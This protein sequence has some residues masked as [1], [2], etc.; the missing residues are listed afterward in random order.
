[1]FLSHTSELRDHPVARSFVAAAEAAVIRAGHAVTDMAYFAARDA[2]PADYCSDMTAEADVYVGII[3]LCYG[4]PVLD[5]PGVSYTELEFETATEFGRPR[6]IFL[7]DESAESVPPTSEPAEHRFRQEAFRRRLL[8]DAGVTVARIASP[9]A[10]ELGLLH[11]LGELRGAWEARA[12]PPDPRAGIPPDATAY[13]TGRE[14][15]LR[16]IGQRLPHSGRMGIHG[17]GGVGKT[18]LVV[19]YLH[20]S[21]DEYPDG[22]FW[23]RADQETSLVGDLA[24]LAWR[25]RLPERMEREQERQVDA[26]LYWLREHDGWLMVIDNLQPAA[27]EALQQWLP[28]GLPGHLLVTSRTPVWSDRMSL[29]PLPLDVARRFLLE[30]TRQEDANAARSVAETVGGL[31][32]ALAQAAAYLSASGRDLASYAQ[33]LKTCL[34]KL[35]REGR[36]DDYPYTVATTWEFSFERMEGEHPPAADLL[37]LCAFLGPDDIPVGVLVAGA[38]ALPEDMRGGLLDALELDRTIA[39]LR[40]YSLVER[41]GDGLRVHRLVQAVVRAA[42]GVD[43]WEVWLGAA[44]RLLRATFPEDADEHPEHWPLCA[45]LQAHAQVA[46]SLAADPR[47][48]PRALSG[49]LDRVGSYLWA[50]GEFGSARPLVERALSIRERVLGPEHP[51]TADSLNSLGVLLVDQRELATAGSLLERGLAIRERVLGPDHPQTAWSLHNLGWLRRTQGDLT[52]ARAMH[53]R[54]LDIRER[55]LGPDHP[56]T[57]WSLH[58]LAV[59]FREGGE[60]AAA[61]LL[62]ERALAVRERVLGPE[63]PTTATSL[64][65]LALLLGHQSQ[66]AAARPLFERALHIRERVLGPDHSYTA[67]VQHYL[68][69]VLRDQGELAAARA[70]LERAL[71]TVERV[72]GPAHPWTIESRRALAE[73]NAGLQSRLDE[74]PDVP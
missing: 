22:V 24:S 53:E 19:H 50:R 13:F 61:Q 30:R 6:L 49:L 10:L 39:V 14:A 2:E 44:I 4:S 11:A 9:A 12:Q 66:P 20:Q 18:Q 28:P 29:K 25:L 59:M 21:R 1:V 55:V 15:E 42:L 40:R 16:E 3:G 35:M 34:D 32:L 52:A 5:R 31:P 51:D 63:H 38:D 46:G 70:L 74:Y 27:E 41:H 62:F 47:M 54:A 71:T 57:A 48:E 36:P 37:R 23:L 60:L 73:I 56:H 68:A 58:N 8:T 72:L 67:R 69:M 33:L 7:V 17:L 43:Q 64:T 65:S 26:V 45:R